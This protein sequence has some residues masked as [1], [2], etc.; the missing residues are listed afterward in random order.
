MNNVFF[1]IIYNIQFIQHDVV[2]INYTVY[3]FEFD[4]EILK[5]FIISLKYIIV[6]IPIVANYSISCHV[7]K[8]FKNKALMK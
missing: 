8:I 6:Y 2:Y 1:F 5:V 7:I 4:F 3:L